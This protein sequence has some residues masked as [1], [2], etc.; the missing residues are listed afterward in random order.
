MERCK[1][2]CACWSGG[3]FGHLKGFSVCL[4]SSTI[5]C[6]ITNNELCEAIRT[7]EEKLSD[8]SLCFVRNCKRWAL[9]TLA[10]S[11]CIICTF[12]RTAIFLF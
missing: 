6:A 8:A 3:Q 1:C 2:V 10:T 5:S 11:Q 9:G 7:Y 4:F 12:I